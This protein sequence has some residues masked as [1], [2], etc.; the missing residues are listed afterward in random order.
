MGLWHH[1]QPRSTFH[2]IVKEDADLLIL[3]V[4]GYPCANHC[5]PV[6]GFPSAM[7]ALHHTNGPEARPALW[8]HWHEEAE[9]Q[10]I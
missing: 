4:H 5:H 1:P 2:K 9:V 7:P 3:P 6:A 10:G 8:V